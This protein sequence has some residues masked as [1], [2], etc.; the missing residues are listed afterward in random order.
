MV[1]SRRVF[2][3]S[4][5]MSESL[6]AR[7]PITASKLTSIYFFFH[8]W[9]VLKY[10]HWIVNI[11]IIKS[12]HP[13]YMNHNERKK[14]RKQRKN[15]TFKR[16]N[17]GKYAVLTLWQWHGEASEQWNRDATTNRAKAVGRL[18]LNLTIG[19]TGGIFFK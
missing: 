3:Q 6:I 11:I 12:S 2:N 5:L 8:I 15:L 9:N 19:R 4:I 10:Y 1:L 16:K 17:N 14:N 13:K 18:N 7:C